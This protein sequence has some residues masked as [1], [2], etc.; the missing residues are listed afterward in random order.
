MPQL[1]FMCSCGIRSWIRSFS[2]YVLVLVGVNSGWIP[3]SDWE[4]VITYLTLYLVEQETRI[5]VGVDGVEVDAVLG[6][7][8]VML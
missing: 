4:H 8:C 6:V 1:G 7:L 2:I 3:A 5:R